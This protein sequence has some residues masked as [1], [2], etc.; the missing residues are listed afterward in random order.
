MSENHGRRW[1]MMLKVKC[2]Q[3]M[4]FWASSQRKVRT[5]FKC[6]KSKIARLYFHWNFHWQ[7]MLLVIPT[8]SG[9]S[10]MLVE[11]WKSYSGNSKQVSF[12]LLLSL[13]IFLPLEI[14][15]LCKPTFCG[16]VPDFTP[17]LHQ[18]HKQ[19]V[20]MQRCLVCRAFS[21]RWSFYTRDH[22]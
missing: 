20:Q 7:R 5:A 21:A 16:I 9:S 14:Q 12:Q 6:P 19:I 8:I 13:H 2:K 18:R 10:L 11:I 1:I 3:T 15:T 4:S 22:K 17:S